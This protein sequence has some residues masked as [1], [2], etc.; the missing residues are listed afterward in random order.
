MGIADALCPRSST[1]AITRE[2]LRQRKSWFE[3]LDGNLSRAVLGASF[4]VPSPDDAP[5]IERR[6]LESL[7]RLC[8]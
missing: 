4:T 1:Q 5:K 6:R 7:Q 8:R 3:K 2:L